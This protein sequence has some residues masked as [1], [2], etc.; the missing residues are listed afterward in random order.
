[1]R[2]RSSR[3]PWAEIGLTP[4]VAGILRILKVT[5]DL[6][7][8]GLAHLLGLPPS[9]LVAIVDDLEQRGWLVRERATTDRRANRLVLTDAGRAAFVDV[10]KVA[11]AHEARTTAALSGGEAATLR[12]LLARLAAQ[13]GLAEAVHPGYRSMR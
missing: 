1:M 2:A 11:R 3:L 12:D 5:P 7:Q 8:Q 9:R 13:Q 4:P 10:A 6:S